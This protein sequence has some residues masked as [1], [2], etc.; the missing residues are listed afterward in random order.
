MNKKTTNFFDDNLV[1]KHFTPNIHYFINKNGKVKQILYFEKLMYFRIKNRD[2]SQYNCSCANCNFKLYVYFNKDNLIN[3][4]IEKNIHICDKITTLNDYIEEI[5]MKCL[6]KNIAQNYPFL[7]P[8]ELIDLLEITEEKFKHLYYKINYR[9]KVLKIPSKITDLLYPEKHYLIL[10]N[11]DEN[12]V[13]FYRSWSF[14]IANSASFFF[15]D[16]SWK[17]KISGYRQIYVISC[18]LNNN[19]F[20]CF[21]ILTKKR[22]FQTYKKIFSILEKESRKRNP[23]V[24]FFNNST[25]VIRDFEQSVIKCF[26]F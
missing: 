20:N 14:T 9:K 7:T 1:I 21:F 11:S 26:N 17:C 10:D 2:Y 6:A 12:I 25:T 5:N 8:S 19:Y 16:G 22:S 4:V 24:P 15:C 13:I 23:T 18:E 3:S